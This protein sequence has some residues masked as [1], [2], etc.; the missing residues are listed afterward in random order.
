[1]KIRELIFGAIFCALIIIGSVLMAAIALISTTVNVYDPFV[2]IGKHEHNGRYY[3]ETYIEVDPEEYIGL[4]V[5]DEYEVS[6]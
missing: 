1:M 2:V 4:D 5:G 3:I 6:E